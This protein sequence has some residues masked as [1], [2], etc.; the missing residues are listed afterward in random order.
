MKK[1][2]T[3]F[4]AIILV[5]ALLAGCGGNG[6]QGGSSGS[7]GGSGA[8]SALTGST[9]DILQQTMDDANAALSEADALP[10]AFTDPTT[11]ENAP[12]ML[13]LTPDDFV[14][15]TVEATSATGALITFAFQ[16]SVVECKSDSD[17]VLVSD[18]IA[19]SFDS[20]KWICVFPEQSLTMVSGAYVLLAVGH[21]VQTDAL[22]ASFR[23]LAGG[24]ASEANVFYHGE[25]GAG[26]GGGDLG[27]GMMP[28][29]LEDNAD[30]RG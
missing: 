20:G 9:A 19:S 22:A 28:L 6:S 27:L 14:S 3:I 25:I 2:V 7:G 12:G 17:A 13:G 30:S 24:V 8:V 21:A 29:P 15:Y 5:C 26:A 23:D 11:S 1:I 16:V 18:L 10:A 4:F